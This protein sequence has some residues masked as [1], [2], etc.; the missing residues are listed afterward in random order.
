MGFFQRALMMFTVTLSSVGF[1][2]E[3]APAGA[4]EDLVRYR[5]TVMR[6]MSSHLKA[7]APLAARKVTFAKHAELHAQ[8]VVELTKLIGEL[9][10][11]GTKSGESDALDTVWKDAKGF[12]LALDAMRAE[13]EKLSS[14]AAAGDLVQLR[15]QVERT[16]DACAA[17]HKSFRASQ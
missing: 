11:K 16:N 1:A 15:A 3:P 14:A 5:Q 17:C 7:L 12:S 4:P 13:A 8:S 6:A 10:P 9:F 2:A